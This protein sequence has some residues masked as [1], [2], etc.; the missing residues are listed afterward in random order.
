MIRIK[1][2]AAYLESIAPLSYQESY[3]NSGLLVGSPETEVKGV[4]IALDT[5]EEVVEEAIQSGCNLIV[6]HHPIMFRGLKG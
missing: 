1:D 5:V 2:V 3:D 4:L 6:S